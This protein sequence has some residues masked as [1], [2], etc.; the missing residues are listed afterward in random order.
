MIAGKGV[1]KADAVGKYELRGEKE[2]VTFL[3][4]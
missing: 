4:D 3:R 1:L 2:S